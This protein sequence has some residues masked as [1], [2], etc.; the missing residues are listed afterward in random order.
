MAERTIGINQFCLQMQE[1][2]YLVTVNT[3][4]AEGK[5]A[6][7]KMEIISPDARLHT[8]VSLAGRQREL[9]LSRGQ[10]ITALGQLGV[11]AR[12]S[13]GLGTGQ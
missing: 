3:A 11:I 6:A 13:L 10:I 1:A 8:E 4:G 7:V 2:G 12:P 9:T 5:H